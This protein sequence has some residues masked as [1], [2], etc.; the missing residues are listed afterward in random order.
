MGKER[1]GSHLAGP[2]CDFLFNR[3]RELQGT[4][5][6]LCGPLA[7]RMLEA[8]LGGESGHGRSRETEVMWEVPEG[9]R[10]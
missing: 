7:L 9:T 5:C 1:G 6:R 10:L 3:L 4:D 8:E 2:L